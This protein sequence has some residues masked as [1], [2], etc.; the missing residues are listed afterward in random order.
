MH[1]RD[2]LAA[3]GRALVTVG[4]EETIAATARLMTRENKGLALVCDADRKVLGTI[5]AM[6]I[7]RILATD[8]ERVPGM[9]AQAVMN[10]DTVVC[11]P[12]DTV[13]HALD[14]MTSRRRRHLPV[15]EHGVLQGVISA[16]DAFEFRYKE[17]ESDAEEMRK[18]VLGIGYQ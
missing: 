2:I 9:Q 5:S 3:K 12:A 11:A 13:K 16:R 8:E 18:Y 14:L 15:I 1:V 4:P 10:V 7:I 6:D 17:K